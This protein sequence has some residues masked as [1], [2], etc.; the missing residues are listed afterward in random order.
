MLLATVLLVIPRGDPA[1]I[2]INSTAQTIK[3]I[4]SI[5]EKK[6]TADCKI[7]LNT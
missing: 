5:N 4:D 7:K 1:F 3:T 6:K 2:K